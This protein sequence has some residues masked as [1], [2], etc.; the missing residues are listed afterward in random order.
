MDSCELSPTIVEILYC[1]Y[2]SVLISSALSFVST[3]VAGAS[4][5]G[6]NTRRYKFTTFS[7][8]FSH[9]EVYKIPLRASFVA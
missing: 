9:W 3:T 5:C 6:P 1:T 4:V 7:L 8:W 2:W